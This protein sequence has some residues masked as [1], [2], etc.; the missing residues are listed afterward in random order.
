MSNEIID[1][2]FE[3]L[4]NE[5]QEPVQEEIPVPAQIVFDVDPA[6]LVSEFLKGKEVSEEDSLNLEFFLKGD[7]SGWRFK[8]IPA[9][10]LEEL[11]ALEAQVSQKQSQEKINAEAQAFLDATDWMIIRA[12]E[13]GE[14]LSPELK[15]ERQAARDR[16]LK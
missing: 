9:P 5:S 10:S 16:I 15:A 13:K 2:E 14:E 6:L 8:N 12:M 11:K 1:A 7:A 4:S 3:T